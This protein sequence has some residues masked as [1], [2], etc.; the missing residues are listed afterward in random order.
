MASKTHR[1]AAGPSAEAVAALDRLYAERFDDFVPRRREIATAFRAAGDAVGSKLVAAASKPS[2]TAW[3]LNQVAR[4]QPE[5][6]V[7]AFEARAKA[8]AAQTTGEGEALRDTA[9]VY[10]E[11]L[12]D[13]VQA[14]SDAV[15]DDGGALT[16]AQG[17]RI[18]AT[19]QAIAGADGGGMRDALVAGRLVADVDVDD[20]FAGVELGAVR[21]EPRATA[22][23][24]DDLAQRRKAAEAG[25]ARAREQT[26]A[27]EPPEP[28][29]RTREH[30]RERELEKLAREHEQQR[31]ARELEQARERV[32]ALEDVAR[33]ARSVAREAEIAAGRAQAEAERL[34][35]AVE[36]VEKC[37]GEA[38]GDLRVRLAKR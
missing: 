20:P 16:V 34:R 14:A 28:D 1:E 5:L 10:R 33:K 11:R 15:R 36:D 26:R 35:R 4:R 19:V 9:R 22:A 38:K 2:R 7:A 25:R 18:S 29:H 6:V 17:R 21:E 31:Q 32:A 3:A 23:P 12:A 27:N 8:V 37:L 30:A 13:L 24:R